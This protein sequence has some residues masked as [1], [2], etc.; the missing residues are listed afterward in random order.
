L[1]QE[2]GFLP[3]LDVVAEEKCNGKL[4]KD[5]EISSNSKTLFPYP[6]ASDAEGGMAKEENIDVIFFHEK[7]LVSHPEVHRPGLP[8]AWGGASSKGA[9]F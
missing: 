9:F 3:D 6:D 1:I 4:K 8:Q 7:I 2:K 5:E